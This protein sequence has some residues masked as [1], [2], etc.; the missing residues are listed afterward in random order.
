MLS[1]KQICFIGGGSMAE[2]MIKGLLA[3]E[4]LAC[5]QVQAVDPSEQRR[6]VLQ[7]SYGIRTVEPIA[8]SL[9]L[10]Q[11]DIVILAV[12]PKQLGAAVD[13]YAALLRPGQLLV[14]VLA[15]I[16][17]AT[18]HG[19]MPT[20]VAVVR[21]MPNTSAAVGLS[22]T[23]ICACAASASAYLDWTEA[24]F[25]SVGSVVRVNECF[26]DAVTALSG[27]GPAYVYSLAEAMEQGGVAAGL[28]TATARELTKQ[29]L[30]GAAQMLASQNQ[31][32]TELR[33]RVTSP[34]GTT[35]A[36]LEVLQAAD[37]AAIMQ[38]AILS[39]A[40]RSRSLAAQATTADS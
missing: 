29:T 30:L 32:A 5:G 33:Q 40:A 20:G 13:Q 39:A 21:A 36:G 9:C 17:L 18:L 3:Q 35:M 14:S 37:F 34:G 6:L 24:L 15:G 8:A 1:K 31:S 4:L 38:Q 26:M 7:Q 2:A 23:A 25:R 11:A 28:D 12:K 19:L 10:Q 27:S 22:A 16:N